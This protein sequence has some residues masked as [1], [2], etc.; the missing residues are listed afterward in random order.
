MILA[1]AKPPKMLGVIS[2]ARQGSEPSHLG[3]R[4]RTVIAVYSSL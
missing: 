2:F 1:H 3:M 4:F